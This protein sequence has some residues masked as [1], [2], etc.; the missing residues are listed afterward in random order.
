MIKTNENTVTFG[1]TLGKDLIVKQ[2]EKSFAYTSIVQTTYWPKP[3]GQS[4]FNERHTWMNIKF[5]ENLLKKIN[6]NGGFWKGDELVIKGYLT[7]RQVGN[8]GHMLTEIQVESIISHTPYSV[9]KLVRQANQN[10]TSQPNH[11]NQ[12]RAQ[13]TQSNVKP[14][15]NNHAMQGNQSQNSQYAQSTP[16]PEHFNAQ[17]RSNQPSSQ[18]NANYEVQQINETWNGEEFYGSRNQ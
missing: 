7:Q 5:N 16:Q 8:E 15:S 4:G 6:S 17:P 9:K 2:G 12:Y 1:G 10:Q 11:P 3:E 14:N 13:N 18:T